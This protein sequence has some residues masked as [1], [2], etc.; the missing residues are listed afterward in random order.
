MAKIFAVKE[1]VTECSAS[2]I[3]RQNNQKTKEKHVNVSPIIAHRN[4]PRLNQLGIYSS[5]ITF[6]RNDLKD[7]KLGCSLNQTSG[8]L[9]FGVASANATKINLYLFDKPVNGRVI[10]TVE[11]KR[12]DNKWVAIVDKDDAESLGHKADQK[13][14]PV[15]YGYR[16]WGPN[17]EYDKNWEPG[18]SSGFKSHVDNQGNRFNP[19]KLLI[20]PYAKEISHDPI[21][22]KAQG[23]DHLDGTLYATGKDFYLRDSAAL[24][25]KSV[26]VTSETQD[27]GQKPQRAVKDDVIYEVHLRGFTK[28]D[29]SIPEEYRGTY[30]GA[31]MKAKYLKDM[32]YT[33]VEFLPMQ[34]FEDDMNDFE[35]VNNN[36]TNYWGYQTINFFSPN[37]RY[38]SDRTAGGPTKEFKEMVKAFHDEGIKVCMDVVYNHSGEGALWN[39]DENTTNVFSYRGLDNKS[40]YELSADNKHYW[41]N[42]GC[43]A[44]MNV[45]NPITRDMFV[46]ATKYWAEEMG[47]DSFRFDLAPVLGN[48]VEKNGFYFD[49]NRADGLIQRLGQVLELRG[50]NGKDGSVD[51]IAE[52]WACGEGSYQVGNFPKKWKEWNDIYR[53]TIRKVFN[54]QE[55]VSLGSF[56]AAV[57]GS[58]SNFHDNVTRSVNFVT[59]HDGFTLKDLFSYN[60]KNNNIKGF[61]SDGG[62]DDNNSWDN[63]ND[64][65]RQAKAMRNAIM[66]L[67]MSKG[68]PMM[69][70]GDEIM[71]TQLGNNNAYNLDTKQNYLDWNLTEGQKDMQEFTRK[72]IK[73]RKKHIAL[74]DEKYYSGY[75]HN[76]NGFKDVTWLKADGTEPDGKYF[77]NPRNSFLGFR[78]DGTE[79][80]DSA[81]SIYT[82]L[83][84]G[85]NTMEMRLPVNSQGKNWYLAV[86][87]SEES[88]IK[89]NFAE[90]GEEMLIKDERYVASPRSMLVFVER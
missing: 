84:K 21:S 49:P 17:W 54:S 27:I 88:E 46:D 55:N 81:A 12:F 62:S 10:K 40:Y 19:N 64:P 30:K 15:Y 14:A 83:N 3:N 5:A 41:D 71:R 56:A 35:G 26:F 36:D 50:D 80:G 79:F 20:D 13:D 1:Y 7:I 48:V 4:L 52:P 34:E 67:M 89:G 82:V 59:C 25:P 18:S 43:G 66:T 28:L 11:M 29:E 57:S 31:A 42:S 23:L 51:L 60:G 78:L 69:L 65:V 2:A 33:M 61:T 73:F 39:N 75:D 77:D 53:S 9:E 47:V 6:G 24:A 16:A 44:N 8:S 58:S 85:D 86:D 74:T 38:S 87:T 45:A 37:R 63:H 72:A 70:G 90:S 22:P 76:H 32:G 68:A